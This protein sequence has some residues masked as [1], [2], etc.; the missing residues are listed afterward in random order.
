MR[1]SLLNDIQSGDTGAFEE[2]F[3]EY[4]SSLCRY[5]LIYVGDPD[6]S[7]EI[8]QNSFV[9]FWNKKK[10][11]TISTSLKSYLYQVVKN[12]SLNHI[13]HLKV[14]KSF[15]GSHH[16]K[17]KGDASDTLI[18]KELQYKIDA[19]LAKLPVER[20]KIFLM[21]RNEGLKYREIADKL[22]LSIKTVE[23]QMGKALKFFRSELVDYL[24]LGLLVLIKYL[25]T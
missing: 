23:N 1:E 5:A 15:E 14:V 25:N 12:E 24:S 9:K 3:N 11:I 6:E 8:V 18:A 21:S 7:E 20:K 19:S 13:K 17:N 16:N 22:G 2:V 10:Q 4:Y